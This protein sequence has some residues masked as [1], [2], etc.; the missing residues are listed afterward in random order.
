MA[1]AASAGWIVGL[2]GASL[3]NVMFM[4]EGRLLELRDAG[5]QFFDCY[6]PL[7][8]AV[9]ASY[10]SVICPLATPASG[11]AANRADVVVDLDALRE[12]LQRGEQRVA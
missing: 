8:T 6:G 5:P 12:A 4:R 2:H 9:G 11:E 10:R 1:A 3:T 7:A